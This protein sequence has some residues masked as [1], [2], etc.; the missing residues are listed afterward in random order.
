[1]SWKEHLA[2]AAAAAAGPGSVT[3]AV[4]AANLSTPPAA[5]FE[6]TA[7]AEEASSR[8]TVSFLAYS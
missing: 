7:L 4:L 6:S 8:S 3:A 5:E 2:A 1:M